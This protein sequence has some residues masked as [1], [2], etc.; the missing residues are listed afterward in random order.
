MQFRYDLEY[1][2]LHLEP[3]YAAM[4]RL[5]EEKFGTL[6]RE[7][8]LKRVEMSPIQRLFLTHYRCSA[9]K[10]LPLYRLDLT[11]FKKVRCGKCGHMVSFTNGGKYGRMRKRL[12]LMLWQA[13]SG[14]DVS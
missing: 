5:L 9:C 14:R 7:A 1:D 13:R 12:A 2:Y 10:L 4:E 3:D 11:H 8:G 6:C